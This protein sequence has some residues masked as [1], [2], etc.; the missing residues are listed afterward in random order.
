MVQGNTSI[1]SVD[2][3]VERADCA[4]PTPDFAPDFGGEQITHAHITA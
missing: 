2:L 4:A 3:G 1:P